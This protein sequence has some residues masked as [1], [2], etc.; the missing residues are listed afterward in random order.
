M[1]KEAVK[2]REY[3]IIIN[4]DS[5]FA[6][7]TITTTTTIQENQEVRD[8]ISVYRERTRGLNK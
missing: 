1:K 8:T 3:I 5:L 7:T 6:P 4:G 2:N